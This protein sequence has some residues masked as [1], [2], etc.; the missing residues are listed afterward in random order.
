A[1]GTPYEETPYNTG[2]VPGTTNFVETLPVKVT[3]SVLK[4][5]QE[6][7]TIYCAVCHGALGD[8]K[9]VT[10]KYGMVAMANFHD[11]RLVEMPDGEIFNTIT[12]GKNLM[13]SYGSQVPIA[14]RWAI[15]AYVRAL[16]RSRLG[17]I[18]DVPE[19][20]RSQFKK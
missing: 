11:K 7:F 16:E 19:Q 13:G 8:G 2:R 4:R 20:F 3:E 9:G 14:D 17:I 6:R 12:Y 18:D 1:R 15:I 10:A 5:G